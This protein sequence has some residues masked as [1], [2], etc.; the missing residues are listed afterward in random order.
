MDSYNTVTNRRFLDLLPFGNPYA[1]APTTVIT[2]RDRSW[3]IDWPYP[4]LTVLLVLPAWLIYRLTGLEPLYQLVFKL[5]LFAGV[6]GSAFFVA[7]LRAGS[8]I[9]ES[10]VSRLLF[11]PAVLL[12]AVVSGGFDAITMVLLIA[13]YYYQT[14]RPRPWVSAV[15]LGLGIALR[16]YPAVLLPTVLIWVW[17]RQGR[18]QAV[19][20]ALVTLAVVGATFVP[21]LADP[22]AFLA[23]LW[24]QRYI[25][26]FSV[27]MPLAAA[28]AALRPHLGLGYV[29][30]DVAFFSLTAAT[31]A[32]LAVL[33]AALIRQR[34]A[35]L[36][37]SLATLLIFYALFPKMHALYILGLYP[38]SLLASARLVRLVWLPGFVWHLLF[39]GML[40][41]AGLAY[42]LAPLTGVWLDTYRVIGLPESGRIA[43]WHGLASLHTLLALAAAFVVLRG[44]VKPIE[45]VRYRMSVRST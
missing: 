39:N 29:P 43:I 32:A 27:A 7:R 21:V 10:A 4:P 13:A 25:G 30:T 9:R 35:L 8:G 34:C 26:P 42:F 17:Q 3:L 16:F 2:F 38:L 14:A 18:R 15:C 31:A 24:S 37:G 5:P 20:Y 28:L 36:N 1:L 12:L 19:H 33:Y 40:G 6:V 22:A 11:N 45:Y 23:T 44:Y 41:A